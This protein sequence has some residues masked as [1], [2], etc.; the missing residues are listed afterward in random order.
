MNQQ[1]LKSMLNVVNYYL[2]FKSALIRYTC[3]S[4]WNASNFFDKLVLLVK[5]HRKIHRKIH[6]TSV[7]NRLPHIGCCRKNNYQKH[8]WFWWS[9]I[10]SLINFGSNLMLLMLNTLIYWINTL[11]YSK[12]FG[13]IIIKL[14]KLLNQY[15]KLFCTI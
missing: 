11:N 3:M 9:N 8:F 6:F 2:D 1:I 13:K 7:L 5:L 4:W 15:F 10:K 14:F 12:K